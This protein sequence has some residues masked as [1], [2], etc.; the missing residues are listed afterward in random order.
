MVEFV[1]DQYRHCKPIL[2][3]GGDP[4][5]LAKAGIPFEANGDPGLILG[6]SDDLATSLERFVTALGQHRAFDRETFPAIV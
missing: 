4:M 3:F 2:A 5:V 6:D 1:K